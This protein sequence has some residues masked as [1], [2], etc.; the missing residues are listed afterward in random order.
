MPTKRRDGHGLRASPSSEHAI[1]LATFQIAR[2]A[3]L[4]PVAL[5]QSDWTR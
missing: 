1:L 5:S 4:A 3:R 2:E